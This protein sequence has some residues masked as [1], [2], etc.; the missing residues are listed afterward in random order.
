MFFL[1]I[2]GNDSTIN[3]QE[4][5]L[6]RTEND[7]LPPLDINQR[8][9]AFVTKDELEEQLKSYAWKKGDFTFT[10][11]GF[12]WVNTA[13]DTNRTVPG[14]FV[15]YSQSADI[16]D[17]PGFS[18][19]AR[20]S[21]LGIFVDGPEISSIPGSKIRG[22][23]EADFEGTPNGT[24]NKGGVQL[25][26]AFVELSNKEKQT[27]ILIGQD[28]EIISLLYPQMLNYLP[29]GFAGNLGY[30][31]AQI[32]FDKGMTFSNNFKTLSQIALVDNI[33]GD[34]TATTG[35]SAKVSGAP[36]IEGR[37][38][39]SFWEQAR[40]GLPITAAVSGHW[41]EQTFGFS[42][43]A[44]TFANQRIQSKP[45][46]TWSANFELDVP[47]T[48]K[49][50]IQGEYYFG[51]NLS[52]FTGGINQGVDLFT[53]NAIRNQGGWIN[54]HYDLSDKLGTNFG[55][56]IDKPNKNDL[57]GTSLPS[58]GITSAR[59]QNSVFFTNFIYHWSSALM[60]GLEFDYWHTKYQRADVSGAEPIFLPMKDGKT[61]R[62]EFVVQYSF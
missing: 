46:K 14:E 6:N 34:Y 16:D 13:F 48:K 8:Y 57:I 54:I 58:N 36:L 62:T 59:L 5:I 50:R 37:L 25:R 1:F 31:R 7:S 29:A 43:I 39:L 60:T 42:P 55:Y 12:I 22:V 28:W 3:A 23:V 51:E 45:I 47:L 2:L 15:L 30:R 11:Y 32:R 9:N 33:V 49:W 41:G 35:V 19:D 61:F 26:K 18:I 4:V 20:M 56:G 27:K 21:R 24:K 10:P 40:N 53:Q 44:G 17:D 38:A 52:S